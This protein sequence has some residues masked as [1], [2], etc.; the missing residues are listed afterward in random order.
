MK[1]VHNL[2][3]AVTFLQPSLAATWWSY[4]WGNVQ[5]CPQRLPCWKCHHQWVDHTETL[6]QLKGYISYYTLFWNL[7]THC[8]LLCKKN[9]ILL[10]WRKRGKGEEK[11]L[12]IMPCS[13]FLLSHYYYYMVFACTPTDPGCS[14]YRTDPSC[15]VLEKH[16][17]QRR[18]QLQE[19][20]I[21]YKQ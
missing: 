13:N 15:W 17:I 19:F 4:L 9:E 6:Q 3:P 5:Q 7:L 18:A 8:L 2:G 20:T 21:P 12:H 16:R 1:E 11:L 14:N 10:I